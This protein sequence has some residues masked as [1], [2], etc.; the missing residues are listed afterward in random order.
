M[1]K[2]GMG[3][4]Q[5]AQLGRRQL[6]AF[7]IL[8]AIVNGLVTAGVGAWLAQTYSAY[9]KKTTAIQNIADLVYERRTRA[10]M[11]VWAIKRNAEL[12]ELRYRKRAYDEAFVAWNTKTQRNIFMIRDISGQKGVTRL[13]T[14]FQELLVPG[15]TATDHCLTKAYDL[16]LN[17]GNALPVLEAC[18]MAGLHQFTLDCAATF[19]NELDRLTRLSFLP[20]SGFSD[21][22]RKVVEARVDKG[23][24]NLPVPKPAPEIVKAPAA[25]PVGDAAA[26]TPVTNAT[27][28]GTQSTAPVT[29]LAPA[30]LDA[31]K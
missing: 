9:Q 13:E 26:V 20:W 27:S 7:A 12:D 6:I 1:S 22:D 5:G 25:K 28:P 15:L 4:L 21:A 18:E 8:S 14:Q 23:C 2:Y 11:V 24:A 31:A 29:T 19:T 30:P 17:G 16:R 10:G 3:L